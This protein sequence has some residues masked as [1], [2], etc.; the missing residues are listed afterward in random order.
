MDL[1]FMGN[2]LLPG[3]FLTSSAARRQTTGHLDFSGFPVDFWIMFTEPR[4]PESELLLSKVGDG[5]ESP[6]RVRF[7]PEYEVNDLC[8]GSIFIRGAINIEDRDGFREFKETELGTFGIVS[9]N[10][11][12]AAP[13]STKALVDLTSAVSVVSSSTFSLRELVFPSVVAM[14]DLEG[15]LLSHFRQDFRWNGDIRVGDGGFWILHNFINSFN[16]F[17]RFNR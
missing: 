12:S 11:L 13:Q 8:Y 6:F 1:S 3:I 17:I 16:N 4:V 10:K 15:S 2:L 9:V 7:A 5:K 14:I